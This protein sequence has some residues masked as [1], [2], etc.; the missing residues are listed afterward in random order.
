MS[1]LRNRLVG[2]LLIGSDG[3]RYRLVE[4]TGADEDDWGYRACID[5]RGA[6][7]FRAV[8][9]SPGTPETLARIERDVRALRALAQVSRPHP[10]IVRCVDYGRVQVLV[11]A[12]PLP[13]DLPFA[14]F[15]TT[16]GMTLDQVLSAHRG[17]GLPVDRTRRIA[18]SV[19][20]ALTELHA[21][22]VLRRGLKPSNVVIAMVNAREIAK[23]MDC[24][25]PS[26][27]E[28]EPAPHARGSSPM[29]GYTAPEMFERDHRRV[30]V[31]SDVFAFAAILFE[32]L[33]GTK[34]FPYGPAE[35]PLVVVARLLNGP[36]PSLA[37]SI[38]TLPPELVTRSDLLVRLDTL[39]TRALAAEPS[40]R[41]AT[42]GEFWTSLDVLLREACEDPSK[43]AIAA[44]HASDE[45]R[46]D[47]HAVPQELL[48]T[49][50]QQPPESLDGKSL[51]GPA[52]WSWSL[53]VAPTRS[54]LVRAACFDA[55][56]E[57][58]IALSSDGLLYWADS[59]WS[60]LPQVA[61]L[62][63]ES[64]RGFAWLGAGELLVF[65]ARGLVGR[66]VPGTSFD[67]WALS[68][69]EL[70]FHGEHVDRDGAV[71]TLVGQR[72]AVPAVR[73]GARV[74]TVATVAQLARGKTTLITEA[75]G[76]SCLRAVTR[77]RD[78]SI[79]A[80]GDFGSIARI[81]PGVSAHSTSVCAGHLCAI[82][83]SRDGGAVTV[84][85][86]GHALSL[87]PKL[88]AQLEAV[89][90]TRD[91]RTIAIDSTGVAW[92]GSDQAR[93]LRRNAGS[94]VRM[95]GEL[96]LTSSV[97]ALFAG[98]QVVR[99]VCDDGAIVEGNAAT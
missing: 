77:L 15:E 23:L 33:A 62:D 19:A 60:R 26:D 29:L 6:E 90:T 71:V 47:S 61:A 10:H 53:R 4:S 55:A 44:T 24:G 31:R 68:R 58:A 75:I 49:A 92:A 76:C 14:I 66:L 57:S 51:A 5:G 79:V 74:D 63:L 16:S 1:L 82:A 25:M 98:I 59:G 34:A 20:S 54:G 48:A 28:I 30:G 8:V 91:L 42:I 64:L 88:E 11:G 86:G 7:P 65:G 2:L 21:S 32:M 41:P 87:S 80:C 27:R 36:R 85:T 17:R 12:S 84:G 50:R 52:S 94:W 69:H 70:T 38:A 9:V 97:V 78:G 43:L 40:D 72:P 22:A 18:A 73:G 39:V 3:G 46:P 37:R 81:E 56:G 45:R 96:G 13:V 35:N 95:S 67:A 89:Q 83:A 99:A 93:L